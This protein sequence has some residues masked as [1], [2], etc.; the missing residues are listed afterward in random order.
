[1]T[2]IVYMREKTKIINFVIPAIFL[3]VGIFMIIDGFKKYGNSSSFYSKSLLPALAL[4]AFVLLCF[5]VLMRQEKKKRDYVKRIR[6]K[7]YRIDGEILGVHT[8][9]I[10]VRKSN[11]VY[12][13]NYYT[14]L[15]K[16]RDPF[17]GEE[18]M[19]ESIILSRYYQIQSN[20]CEL[21]I[22]DDDVLVESADVVENKGHWDKKDII[23]IISVLAVILVLLLSAIIIPLLKT[24]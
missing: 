19:K 24:L 21:R 4:I 5:Y 15:V 13:E 7:G 12:H 2:K 3:A 8:H 9:T 17:S 6:E 1:M 22:L 20:K 14:F 18:I 16:F 11:G 10:T 23:I